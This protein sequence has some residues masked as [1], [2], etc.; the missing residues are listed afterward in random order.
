MEFGVWAGVSLHEIAHV[1]LAA[2]P[3]GQDAL[4]IALL[5]KLGRVLLLIPLCFILIY[6]MKRNGKAQAGTKIEFP[7][8]LIGFILMSIFGSYVLG[9][10]IS[11]PEHIMNNVANVTTFILTMAMVGPGL[12]VSLR[13]LRT[14]A[15]KP[16]IAMSITSILL[17]LLTFF[18][19]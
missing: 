14:K 15:M 18:T 19:L 3:A 8:F 1:A 6:W 12:N 16:L 13:A 10:Y 7:W 5:A 11:V 17:T 9:N 4:A 2:A